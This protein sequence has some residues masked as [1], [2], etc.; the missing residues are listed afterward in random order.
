MNGIEKN[1]AYIRGVK[2]LQS[3]KTLKYSISALLLL[4]CLCMAA[5]ERTFKI[6]KGKEISRMTVC[7][8]HDN[9][10]YT[11]SFDYG[12]SKTTKTVDAGFRSINWVIEAPSKSTALTIADGND[13]Y[14]VD[15]TYKGKE[16]H[17]VIK[18]EGVK[19]WMQGLGY[20]GGHVLKMGERFEF[21]NISLHDLK[22]YDMMAVYVGEEDRDGFRVHHFCLSPAGALAKFWK[23]H[24]YY[25]TTT[26]DLVAYHA[27][28][29]LPGTPE[30]VWALEK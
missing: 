24:Y 19:P 17:K 5:G 27:V 7:E 21:T 30:T 4:S 20:C 16:I 1:M 13:G 15:G 22:V 25:D 23:A 29:G 18:K 10:R 6:S 9:G 14:H 8:S 2:T 3:M 11:Y 28:E 12:D 26:G